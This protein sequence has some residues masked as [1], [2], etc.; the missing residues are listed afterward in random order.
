MYKKYYLILDF[1]TVTCPS[2]AKIVESNQATNQNTYQGYTTSSVGRRSIPKPRARSSPARFSAAVRQLVPDSTPALTCRPSH[3]NQAR[4]D[5]LRVM[6]AQ[7]SA[8]HPAME[9]MWSDHDR[10]KGSSTLCF[11]S[12]LHLLSSRKLQS[13]QVGCLCLEK[14]RIDGHACTFMEPLCITPH[15]AQLGNKTWAN[16]STLHRQLAPLLWLLDL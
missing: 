3:H 7:P 11:H 2:I 16:R 13:T 6:K 10:D 4:P 9:V 8:N 15:L 14:T 1:S 5:K 12:H